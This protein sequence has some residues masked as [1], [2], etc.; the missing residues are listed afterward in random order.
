MNIHIDYKKFDFLMNSK[1]FGCYEVGSKLYN[2]DDENSDSDYLVI[3][4]PFY[5]QLISPFTNHHQYQYKDVKNN[6]DYNFVDVI[7]FISNLVKGDSTINFELIHSKQI[8]ND[9]KLSFLHRW[10]NRFY[11]YNI[12][13]AYLGFS[14]RDFKQVPKQKNCRDKEHK[15]FH[16]IRSHIFVDQILKNNFELE[17]DTLKEI[18]NKIKGKCDN[19]YRNF[20]DYYSKLN[21]ELRHDYLN[22]KL[23][24]GEINRYLEPKIQ[25]WI[26]IELED[27]IDINNSIIDLRDMYNTNE[28][29][30]IKYD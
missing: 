22:P 25:D 16:A 27:I 12:V 14:E 24:N 19:N 3:Y 18:K 26:E 4:Q 23:D 6:I 28:D 20:R 13:K 29:V 2:L 10:K 11:T 15:I 7:T 21:Y 1:K 9:K 8:E 5:N 30:N 17:S